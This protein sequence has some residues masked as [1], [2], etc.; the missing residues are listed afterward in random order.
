MKFQL[1]NM[2]VIHCCKNLPQLS[3]TV[4]AFWVVFLRVAGSVVPYS[5][6]T[7]KQEWLDW[8][9][10]TS[11]QQRQKANGSTCSKWFK[12]MGFPRSNHQALWVSLGQIPL[13]QAVFCLD[14]IW[15]SYVFMICPEILGAFGLSNKAASNAASQEV[16]WRAV[17][18][19]SG[20]C[21]SSPGKKTHISVK[22][23]QTKSNFLE[24]PYVKALHRITVA[25]YGIHFQEGKQPLEDPRL[26]PKQIGLFWVD[27]QR[28]TPS[29]LGHHCDG[30]T[31]PSQH[32]G[33]NW[34]PQ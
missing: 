8:S 6:S 10:T 30:G 33:Q 31:P 32:V 24:S 15:I 3:H 26:W 14:F 5:W 29:S 28:T 1:R 17:S 21:S 16:P 20:H 25:S 22:W 4:D 34:V 13:S 7:Q 27:V 18:E 19:H 23:L 2:I 11:Q 12:Q 9:H